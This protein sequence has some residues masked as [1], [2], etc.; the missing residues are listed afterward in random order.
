M[1]NNT[2]IQTKKEFLEMLS[3]TID[4]DEVV[5]W[6]QNTS[7]LE[8][9]K[10]LNEKRVTFGFAADAF[11]RK[12]GVGDVMRNRALFAAIICDKSILSEE[13][14]RLLPQKAPRKK[15]AKP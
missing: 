12:D 7:T 2:T 13:A 5:L 10:K 15:K 9:K 6:T 4:D 8:L 11:E 3:N 14:K 1:S